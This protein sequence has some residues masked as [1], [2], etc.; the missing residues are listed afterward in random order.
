MTHNIALF[1]AAAFVLA[2]IPGPGMLYVATRTIAGGRLEGIA[3]SLGNAIGGFVHVIAAAL[4]LSAIIL[5]SAQL[6][7]ALKIVGALYLI[8]LGIKTLRTARAHTAETMQQSPPDSPGIA[9]AVREGIVVEATNPK[10]AAFFLAFLPQ[11]V[12]PESGHLVLQFLILGAISVSLN[13]TADLIAV[14]AASGFRS[15]LHRNAELMRRFR[16]TSGGI[17]IALG[18]GTLLARR[19]S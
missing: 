13:T 15:L 5:A 18:A 8:W 11:F 6:F 16:Q 14:L 12:S 1:L 10:T 9:K 2:A 3:S 17:L 7:T 4:G 19:P